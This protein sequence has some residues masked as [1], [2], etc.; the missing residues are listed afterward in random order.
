MIMLS[1]DGQERGIYSSQTSLMMLN[2][3]WGEG[4]MHALFHVHV[5]RHTREPACFGAL[6]AASFSRECVL[7]RPTDHCNHYLLPKYAWVQNQLRNKV[8]T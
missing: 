8:T 3:K 4:R 1:L 6:V 5:V 2:D 7:P